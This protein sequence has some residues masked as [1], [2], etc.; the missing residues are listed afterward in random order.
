[1]ADGR[2]L[3]DQHL[4]AELEQ[5]E[6][7]NDS[8]QDQDEDEGKKATG[9][10]EATPLGEPARAGKRMPEFSEC[11]A[12]A[13]AFPPRAALAIAAATEPANLRRERG[14]GYGRAF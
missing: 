12:F 14:R 2:G 6:G 8:D 4:V 7:A 1:M 5:R 9:A 11:S 13:H 3:P 10:H